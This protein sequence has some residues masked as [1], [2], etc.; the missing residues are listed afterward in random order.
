[1]K[2]RGCGRSAPPS[3]VRLRQGRQG[4]QAGV[5]SALPLHPS[6]LLEAFPSKA[7][8]PKTRPKPS[9]LLPPPSS[10]DSG[11]SGSCIPTP[12]T[13]HRPRD[14]RAKWPQRNYRKNGRPQTQ[15][16]STFLGPRFVQSWN[17][18]TV[19]TTEFVAL[20]KP[21]KPALESFSL[22]MNYGSMGT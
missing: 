8:H 17:N 18:Q 16:A 19:T 3:P 11:D 6:R 13:P 12:P 22:R 10:P 1:M 5:D 14:A 21:C 4:Y 20:G 15:L 9:P 2:R 7:E